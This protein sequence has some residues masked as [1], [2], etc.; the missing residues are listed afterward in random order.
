M[1]ALWLNPIVDPLIYCGKPITHLVLGESEKV[2]NHYAAR[3][4][5]KVPTIS[6]I[7]NVLV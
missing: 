5:G 4:A 3:F 2:D 6:I 7:E 1:V